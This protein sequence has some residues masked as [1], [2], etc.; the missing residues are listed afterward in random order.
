VV[1]KRIAMAVGNFEEREAARVV[2]L[3]GTIARGAEEGVELWQN[4]GTSQSGLAS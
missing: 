1:E 2:V 4:G 3:T